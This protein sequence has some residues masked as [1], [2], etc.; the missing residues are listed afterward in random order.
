[1]TGTIINIITV[2]VGSTLGMVFGARIPEKL[3]ATVVAGMGLFTA[4]MGFQMFIKTGN[5]L[6]VLG[7]LLIGILLGE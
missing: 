2:I 5:S 4:A 7:A 6:I 3:K 1:M